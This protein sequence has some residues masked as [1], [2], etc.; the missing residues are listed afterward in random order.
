MEHPVSSARNVHC[1]GL[2]RTIWAGAIP[3]PAA[4]DHRRLAARW[5]GRYDRSPRQRAIGD[6]AWA[7]CVPPQFPCRLW[8]LSELGTWRARDCTRRQQADITLRFSTSPPILPSFPDPAGT[9]PV[10]SYKIPCSSLQGT[11]A[12][13]AQAAGTIWPRASRE[14]LDSNKFPVFFHVAGKQVGQTGSQM[15]ASAGGSA[16]NWSTHSVTMLLRY[17]NARRAGVETS[18]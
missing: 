13:N 11:C 16:A 18:A 6:T 1:A 10:R 8:S 4:E 17:S 7:A 15:T 9:L 12:R 2:H 3:G 14:R 5:R